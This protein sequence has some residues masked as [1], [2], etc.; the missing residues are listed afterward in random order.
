MK[1]YARAL[2]SARLMH[3]LHA[4]ILQLDLDVWF[5]R[6]HTVHYP[7]LSVGQVCSTS[8]RGTAVGRLL[9]VLSTARYGLLALLKV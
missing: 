9:K 1:G 3:A 5:A 8:G 2:D 7:V 4:A 6:R